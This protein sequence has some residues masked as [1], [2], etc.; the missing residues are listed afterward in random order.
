[1][2]RIAFG[3]PRSDRNMVC[4]LAPGR[5][6]VVTG[7]TGSRSYRVGRRVRKSDTT[8]PTGGGGVTALAATCHTSVT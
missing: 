3:C 7:I 8:Q 2:A 5:G 6:S 1:M 4:R